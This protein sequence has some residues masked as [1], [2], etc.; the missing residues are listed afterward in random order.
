[1]P[2]S[3]LLKRYEVKAALFSLKP[4]YVK[5]NLVSFGMALQQKVFTQACLNFKE[6]NF[7]TLKWS[8]RITLT[9]H[10]EEKLQNKLDTRFK[11]FYPDVERCLKYD[12]TPLTHW[13]QA[14]DYPMIIHLNWR[15]W[16]WWISQLSNAST[17]RLRIGISSV[18]DPYRKTSGKFRLKSNVSTKGTLL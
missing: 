16:Y 12:Y 10:F 8:F 4:R 3:N 7:D 5:P 11:G 14:C 1:M 18:N 15:R 6:I 2:I 13:M 9:T 17:L